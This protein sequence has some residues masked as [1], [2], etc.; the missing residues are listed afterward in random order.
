MNCPKCGATDGSWDGPEYRV[1][2]LG[3]EALLYRCRICGYKRQEHTKDWQPPP[4]E[5][6]EAISRPRHRQKLWKK[7]KS[8]LAIRQSDADPGSSPL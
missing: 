2:C 4:V 7:M 3:A 1:F 8:W 6:A 5:I